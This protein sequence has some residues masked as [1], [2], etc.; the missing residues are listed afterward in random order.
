MGCSFSRPSQD[1][2]LAI[3]QD[4]A[5]AVRAVRVSLCAR[6]RASITWGPLP[7]ITP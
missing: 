5:A 1:V 7:P 6:A 2:L 4:D 3:I